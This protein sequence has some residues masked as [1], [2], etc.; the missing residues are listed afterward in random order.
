VAGIHDAEA[1][2]FRIGEDDE[3]RIRWIRVPLH[4]GGTEA[5]ESLDL[6][7]LFRGVVDDEVDM[8]SRMLFGRRVRTLER[9]TRSFARGRHEDREFVLGLGEVNG[10][11]PEH[12][13]PERHRTIDVVGAEYDRSKPYHEASLPVRI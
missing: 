13:G 1:I 8:K 2:S 7:C 5:D 6:G 11:I 3:V 9:D 10:S 12:L 4:P